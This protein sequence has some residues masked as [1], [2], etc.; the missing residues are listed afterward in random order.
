MA[1]QLQR[2][3]W[4]QTALFALPERITDEVQV[5]AFSPFVSKSIAANKTQTEEN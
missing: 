2:V 4:Q 1:S 3:V 5:A